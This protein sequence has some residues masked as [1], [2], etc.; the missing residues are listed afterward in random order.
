MSKNVVDSI[1]S[2]SNNNNIDIVFIPSRRQVDNSGGYVNNW[3]TKQF[4]DY[5]N[6]KSNKKMKIERDH[7]GPGQGYMDD[8][9]FESLRDDAKYLDIIHIDPWKKYKLYSEGLDWTIKCINYLYSINPHIEYEIGTE[10][11]IRPTTCD[12]LDM[13]VKDIKCAL[14]NNIFN[15]IKYLVIQ[16]GTKLLEKENIGTFDS[17][18]LTN[19]L[20]VAKKHNLTAKEH[21]GDW[22]DMDTVINKESLGLECIN[23][24]PEF[25]EIET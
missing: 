2:F 7:G 22:I 17:E 25:G 6:E 10:E 3:T 11:G 21:N 19:M 12:E 1:V 5:I 24:A 4:Y 15:Q 13:F 16:C 20:K 9:G 14:P 8:D 18:K 23:I